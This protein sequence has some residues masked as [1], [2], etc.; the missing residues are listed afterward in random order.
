MIATGGDTPSHF[1]DIIKLTGDQLTEN[2]YTLLMAFGQ[3]NSG[4][5]QTSNNGK[6]KSKTT[7]VCR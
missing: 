4:G 1:V 7:K 6:G 3:L 2:F 5:R